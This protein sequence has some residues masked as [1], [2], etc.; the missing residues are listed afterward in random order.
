VC[1][2]LEDLRVDVVNSVLV[3]SENIFAVL[4]LD[5]EFDVGAKELGKLPEEVL[6]LVFSQG[7]H[8][9]YLL[10]INKIRNKIIQTT[11]PL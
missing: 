1:G 4:S 5:Q 2:H 8:I 6:G 11:L 10:Y 7:S 3:E 9:Y